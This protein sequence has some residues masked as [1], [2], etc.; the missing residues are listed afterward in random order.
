[1]PKQAA[2]SDISIAERDLERERERKKE[3]D[4]W[5]L[6]EGRYHGDDTNAVKMV[7]QMCCRW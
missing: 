7:L 1:L 6:E 3:K 4:S 5:E 2:P